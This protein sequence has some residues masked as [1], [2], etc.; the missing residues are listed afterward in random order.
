M[1]YLRRITM[2]CLG[3]SACLLM[4]GGASHAQS[5][6]NRSAKGTHGYSCTGFVNGAPFANVGVVVGDG[7]GHWNGR[8]RVSLNGDI[9]S[10]THKTRPD[11]PAVVNSDCTGSVTYEV[12]FDGYP[13]PD[14]HFDFV[15]VSDG[16]ELKGFPTEPGY[17]V[18]CQLTLE[19]GR[20]P[21]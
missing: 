14:A 7:R 10:W 2:A 13:A 3:I 19:K 9:H 11:Q 4:W 5:C 1:L 18:V 15:I 17:A 21:W 12:T 6:S 20:N 8:G 16:A